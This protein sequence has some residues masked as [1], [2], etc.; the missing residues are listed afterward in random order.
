MNNKY[1]IRELTA[2]IDREHDKQE[3]HAVIVELEQL[4]LKLEKDNKQK[5]WRNEILSLIGKILNKLPQIITLIS[6]IKK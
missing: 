3:S 2:L 5:Q 4:V 1:L 6:C